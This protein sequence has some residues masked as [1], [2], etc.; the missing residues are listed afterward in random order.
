MKERIRNLLGPGIM[1]R[2]D[3]VRHELRYRPAAALSSWKSS[4]QKNAKRALL[5]QSFAGL[6]ANP[7]EVLIGAN[8]GGS[9]G[10]IHH[11]SAIRNFS[12]LR[13]EISPSE[14]AMKE[15]SHHDLHTTFRD[16]VMSFE[17]RGMRVIHSHVFPYF[18]EW[19]RKHRDSVA[20]WVH[21]Y[22]SQYYPLDSAPLEP[23]QAEFN[24]V[25]IEEA[26]HADVRISVSRWQQ[27]E[28][29]D[30]HG[31]DTI[32]IPNGVNIAHCDLAN[33]E[34]FRSRF[35]H[36][37]F[38]LY[39]GRNEPVKNPAEF[40]RLA[41]RMPDQR[42]MMIG[43]SLTA[44]ELRESWGIECPP[45][46]VLAGSASHLEVQDALAACAVVVATSVR[47]GLP[48]LVLEALA[49][50]KPV[51]VSN[52]AG[53]V[54]AV[55]YGRFGSIYEPGDLDDLEHKTRFALCGPPE[56]PEARQ[57]VLSMYDWRVVAPQLDAIYSRHR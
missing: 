55:E 5:R 10:I 28:L 37:R 12:R 2:V 8:I 39:V 33:A 51:V 35:G 13:V 32:H 29:L 18:I 52:E 46:V 34:R 6:H 23:W 27:K 43:K 24:R 54:E 17:P 3:K 30:L 57:H 26:R 36:D 22:H 1:Q 41:R 16:D 15:L 50:K 49:H 47:E 38:I 40:I 11:I 31:I 4:R 14:R 53:S 48:T 56:I 21:T 42:F 44:A 9:N 25:L 19:C 7:P 45:N 20:L